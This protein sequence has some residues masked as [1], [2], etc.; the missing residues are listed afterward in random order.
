M[1]KG[2]QGAGQTQFLEGIG[3]NSRVSSRRSVG[4]EALTTGASDGLWQRM[5]G[6][7]DLDLRSVDGIGSRVGH[8]CKHPHPRRTFTLGDLLGS[9]QLLTPNFVGASHV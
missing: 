6:N 9:V 2:A 7:V 1:R 5:F 3:Q 4:R 8:F